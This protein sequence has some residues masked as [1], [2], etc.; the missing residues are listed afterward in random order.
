MFQTRQKPLDQRPLPKPGRPEA[1]IAAKDLKKTKDGLRPKVP[2][3]EIVAKLPMFWDGLCVEA[4]HNYVDVERFDAL[5][6]KTRLAVKEQILEGA[7][8]MRG[9][10]EAKAQVKPKQEKAKPAP[11]RIDPRR[12]AEADEIEVEDDVEI[13][14]DEP[15]ADDPDVLS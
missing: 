1:V 13:E 11:A 9:Y 4:G 6:R 5:P 7:F 8:M 3:F 15:P 2:A 10:Q 14:T 12:Q